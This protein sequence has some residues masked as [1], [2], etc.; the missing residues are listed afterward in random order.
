M[1]NSP[2]GSTR[3]FGL[4]GGTAGAYLLW[5]APRSRA[6]FK[7]GFRT[8]FRITFPTRTESPPAGGGTRASRAPRHSQLE[9]S[10]FRGTEKALASGA[11]DLWPLM[12]DLPSAA[13]SCTSAG[14]GQAN[15]HAVVFQSVM[16]TGR[17]MWRRRVAVP[18]AS[19]WTPGSRSGTFRMRRL[20]RCLERGV[21]QAVCNGQAQVGL[22]GLARA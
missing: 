2:G 7:S 5:P 6:C 13:N 3:S 16:I 10:T 14:L 21:L 8:R 15:L 9:W 4:V 18:H 1:R 19:I 20:P 22:I 11:L 12:G 17:R